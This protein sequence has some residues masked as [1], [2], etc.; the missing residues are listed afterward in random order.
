M[1]TRFVGPFSRPGGGR[2]GQSP[3]RRKRPP[4]LRPRPFECWFCLV[5]QLR[6]Y[7]TAGLAKPKI[8]VSVKKRN[9]LS[10]VGA[11]GGQHGVFWVVGI[12]NKRADSR[13]REKI[14]T[15]G[16]KVKRFERSCENLPKVL[17]GESLCGKH[18]VGAGNLPGAAKANAIAVERGVFPLPHFRLEWYGLSES[19]SKDFFAFTLLKTV[20]TQTDFRRYR[21]LFVSA[22]CSGLFTGQVFS[23]F[24]LPGMPEPVA[25][26][27][28]FSPRR[29]VA[30]PTMP[31]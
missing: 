20:K 25:G 27:A 3:A 4:A 21:G 30:L 17:G 24:R 2:R 13:L 23:A 7:P 10:K 1:A 8:K 15:G 29:K 9:G 6:Q 19:L 14:Q 12:K 28:F 18:P 16:K 5:K 22:R 26:K 31:A 11:K